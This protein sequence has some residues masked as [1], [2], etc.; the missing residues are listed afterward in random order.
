MGKISDKLL[1]GVRRSFSRSGKATFAR[2]QTLHPSVVQRLIRHR[3]RQR[4]KAIAIVLVLTLLLVGLGSVLY[5]PLKTSTGEST[6][7]ARILANIMTSARPLSYFFYG[8]DSINVLVVGLDKDPP[9]RSDTVMV[10][11]VGLNDLQINILSIPRDLL[12]ILPNGHQDKLAHAYAYGEGQ[13]RNG[14][15][16]VKESI[17]NLL[18]LPID[19]Y[20]AVD[21][22]GF[23]KTVDVIG[24]I[25][26]YVDKHLRYRDRAQNLVIDIPAGEQ[27]MDGETLLDYVRFRHDA[28]GDIGRTKRQQ[29]A[30]T[31]VLKKLKETRSWDTTLR[32]V[33]TLYTSVKTNFTL[34]QLV[35]LARRLDDFSE[36]K[37]YAETLNSASTLIKGI[38]Y[39]QATNKDI[40]RGVEFLLVGKRFP[41][42]YSDTEL[43]SQVNRPDNGQ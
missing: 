16:W 30:L 1:V 13:E 14:I 18:G 6:T 19:F 28:L 3:K 7:R 26:I 42:N 39:Q 31:A 27:V 24:G 9:H 17:E 25:P 33:R 12:V 32:L 40:L 37:I 21:F 5:W 20:V 22:D 15:R 4:A 34:D 29:Q 38:S 35:A 36:D 23:V 41:E 10:V 2:P 43:P 8:K 11:N